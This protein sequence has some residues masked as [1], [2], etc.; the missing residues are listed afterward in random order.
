M[1]LLLVPYWYLIGPVS[2]TSWGTVT[3]Q[4]C[5]LY[6][7]C[8]KCSSEDQTRSCG[9]CGG[10]AGTHDLAIGRTMKAYTERVMSGCDD[11]FVFPGKHFT[12]HPRAE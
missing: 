8:C 6:W 5:S 11:L 7:S 10:K 2:Q 1:V 3:L 4:V 9:S 12:G